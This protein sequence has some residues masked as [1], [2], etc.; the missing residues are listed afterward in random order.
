MPE[1]NW[2]TRTTIKRTPA[3]YQK[4]CPIGAGYLL[5]CLSKV[6]VKGNLSS[7]QFKSLVNI[8]LLPHLLL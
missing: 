2:I 1:I 7:T 3:K 4:F 6:S 5:R 8:K